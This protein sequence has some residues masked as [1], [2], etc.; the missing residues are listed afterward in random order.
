MKTRDKLAS[1]RSISN[2]RS[3]FKDIERKRAEWGHVMNASSLNRRISSSSIRDA[4]S[5]MVEPLCTLTSSGEG[6]GDRLVMVAPTGDRDIVVRARGRLN[7]AFVN[8]RRKL[9]IVADF[10]T[11]AEGG[12]SSVIARVFKFDDLLK[13]A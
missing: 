1:G 12:W 11:S 5:T 7:K 8:V 6:G 2:H 3:P 4:S 9:I 13:V 10:E